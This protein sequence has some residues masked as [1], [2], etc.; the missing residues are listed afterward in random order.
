[1]SWVLLID[2]PSDIADSGRG[3]RIFTPS[4]AVEVVVD[5]FLIFNPPALVAVD[6]SGGRVGR[7]AVGV[8]VRFRVNPEL[9]S[10]LTAGLELGFD[11]AWAAIL[12]RRFGVG[13][14][15]GL[16]ILIF[17]LLS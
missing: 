6:W 16:S 10:R 17:C 7:C 2:S 8:P 13:D 5:R 14:G 4:G 11:L 3:Y 15:S 12:E 9:V 1:M